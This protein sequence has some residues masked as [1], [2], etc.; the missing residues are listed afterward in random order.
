MKSG[1][2]INKSFDIIRLARFEWKQM[3][4]LRTKKCKFPQWNEN[5]LSTY[6]GNYNLS[7]PKN[8]PQ[9]QNIFSTLV[10]CSKDKRS[11]RK[12][13]K[14]TNKQRNKSQSHFIKPNLLATFDPLCGWFSFVSLYCRIL[15]IHLVYLYLKWSTRCGVLFSFSL[16]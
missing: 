15:Y 12:T 7:Y 9:Q 14:Q 11:G 2:S 8:Q 5:I 6:V 10:R 3:K 16:N 1:I 13:N 4:N